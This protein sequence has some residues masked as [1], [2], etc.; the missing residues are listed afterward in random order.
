MGPANCAVIGCSN[1]T[2]KLKKWK[3]D[4]VECAE[5]ICC[6]DPPFR[7]FMFPSIKRNSDKRK[8]WVQLMKRETVDKKP[9]QPC[10]SD[11][12]CSKHF[13][14]GE[15]TEKNPNPTLE[16]GYKKDIATRQQ[17]RRSIKT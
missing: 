14:D 12:V 11:R 10:G 16:L 15:P 2:Q 6:C 7:L 13:V 5:M 4:H 17:P 9:W 8:Q 1:S 3:E